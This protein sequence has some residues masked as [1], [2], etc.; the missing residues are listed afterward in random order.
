MRYLN[1]TLVLIVFFIGCKKDTMPSS[2]KLAGQWEL[3]SSTGGMNGQI[4]N[5][6]TGV[7]NVL[8]LGSSAYNE[9]RN[10]VIIRQGKYTT[11]REMSMLS[12]KEEDRILFDDPTVRFFFSID[13]D[14]L[15]IHPDVYDGGSVSYEKIK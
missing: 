10:K 15:S 6:P 9:T 4:I 2:A 1:F 13:G 14:V 3:K 8:V 12:N 11:K 5:Y 7:G